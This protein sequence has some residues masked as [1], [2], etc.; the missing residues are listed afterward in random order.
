M[1]SKDTTGKAGEAAIR[2][3]V[4]NNGKSDPTKEGCLPKLSMLPPIYPA[5]KCGV[6]R[7]ASSIVV[8]DRKIYTSGY[9]SHSICKYDYPSKVA[10]ANF[11]KKV[12][13]SNPFTENKA[14]NPN[15]I[16]IIQWE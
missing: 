9:F 16:Y 5:D 7:G 4:L 6:G 14:N 10:V 3:T 15:F 1:Y 8:K 13:V 2:R 12:G 11:K